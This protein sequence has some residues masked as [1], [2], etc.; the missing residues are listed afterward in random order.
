MH[1]VS[2]NIAKAQPIHSKSGMSGIFKQPVTGPVKIG[3][4]GLEGD[5]IVD[6]QSHLS[7]HRAPPTRIRRSPDW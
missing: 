2:I 5:T 4:L 6:T 1:L 3:L 7:R